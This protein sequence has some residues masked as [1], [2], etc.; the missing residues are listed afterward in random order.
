MINNNL[1]V[2][3]SFD[4][5][6]EHNF[7]Q[8]LWKK[9]QLFA[10]TS[11]LLM[12]QIVEDVGECLTVTKQRDLWLEILGEIG[13]EIKGRKKHKLILKAMAAY[14]TSN[15]HYGPVLAD[16][17]SSLLDTALIE[18]RKLIF[19]ARDGIAPYHAAQILKAANLS[20]YS[21]VELHLIYI[22]RTM[23]YSSTGKDDK[24]SSSDSHVKEYL[25]TL[26]MR[27]PEILKKYILQETGLKQGD[28]CLFVD[29]G[30][31][32]SIISP[33]KRQLRGMQ[34]SSPF[35]FLISHT[36]HEK[37]RHD[38]GRAWGFLAHREER[39]LGPVD[40]A[41][42]NPAV[43]WIEDTHQSVVNS[44]KI[45]VVNASGKI[46]PAT[47]EKTDRGLQAFELH[48]NP[49]QT[50][51]ETLDKYLIKLYGLRGALDGVRA[52][53]TVSMHPIAWR[54]A[55]EGLRDSFALFLEGLRSG[56]RLLLMPHA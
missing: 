12:R 25:E 42:G 24:I 29:V 4:L 32:G 52:S 51:R 47:V 14:A 28:R 40:K 1:V 27:D 35:C 43:H 15:R 22:S 13:K 44:P 30:F 37:T 56:K 16:W 34:I 33:I 7:Q 31:A 9:R 46:V 36:D 6:S 49:V 8:F 11:D 45:L 41:G 54:A 48:G 50:C 17:A 23:A 55:S 39:P 5:Y 18:R 26:Q 3:R 2:N 53:K 20:K 21:Q 10:S 19:L 38:R